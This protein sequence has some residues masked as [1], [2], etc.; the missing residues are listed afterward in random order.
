MKTLV[1]LITAL[2]LPLILL[3]GADAQERFD[4]AG[5]VEAESAMCVVPDDGGAVDLTLNGVDYTCFPDAAPGDAERMITNCYCG[6]HHGEQIY[7]GV[8]CSGYPGTATCCAD[9]CGQLMDILD[10]MY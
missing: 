9:K 7:F 10:T 5:A 1:A 4:D 3:V 8:D 2:A 6:S